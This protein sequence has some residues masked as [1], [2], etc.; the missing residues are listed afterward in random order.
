MEDDSVDLVLGLERNCST[1]LILIALLLS[2]KPMT[3]KQLNI[4][5][6]CSKTF[7]NYET[8]LKGDISKGTVDIVTLKTESGITRKHFKL[9]IEKLK[10]VL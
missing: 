4:L 10:E 3:T 8:S 5:L 6:N 7:E 1:K 2:K 9:N